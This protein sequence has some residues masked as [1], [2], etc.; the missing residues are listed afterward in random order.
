VSE[1]PGIHYAKSGD[2]NIAYQVTG[3]GPLDLVM[4][5]GLVSHLEVSRDMPMAQ[6]MDRRFSSV[7][8]LIRFDKRGTGLSDRTAGIA[9]LEDRMDDVR[10][11]MDA[12][13][14]ERAALMGT[15]EGGAMSILFAAT[16]PDR[17]AAL[18][19][20]DSFAR[21][22]W[23]PD[24]PWGFDAETM[25]AVRTMVETKWG[26]GS[27]ISMFFP[28]VRDEPKMQELF[29][30]LERYSA[31]PAAALAIIEMI[32]AIDVRSVLP[33]IGVPTLVMHRLG[34]PMIGPE[35]GRVLAQ[36]IP[37]ARLFEIDSADHLATQREDLDVTFDEIQEFL[38]GQRGEPDLDRVLVTVLFTDI[39]GSTELAARLGDHRW[40]ELLDDHDALVAREVQRFRGRHI[41]ATG[42]GALATFDGPARAIQ[43]ACSIR[44]S[45]GSLGLE[46]RAGLHT[47]E[48]E[49]RGEDVGGIAVHIA[50]RVSGLAGGG[51]VLV[52]NGVPPLVAGSGIDFSDRGDYELKGVPGTWRLL[53]V[54]S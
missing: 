2:L 31:T 54:A 18:V 53:A 34:D 44:D 46:V 49:L 38:T 51:D 40:R 33:T 13:G 3:D 11:V 29:S 4:V 39:V 30:R 43:C 26:D 1:D 23:A 48:I 20:S 28:S 19:L 37:T 9:T 32:A 15:S 35:H 5:P 25:A 36:G 50:A 7:A 17:T 42:D 10:A 22:A 45:A 16:Y 24:Y 52:S 14:S 41:K 47:G 27:F 21:I 6:Y 12:V 8:R